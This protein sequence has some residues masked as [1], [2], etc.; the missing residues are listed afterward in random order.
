METIAEKLQYTSDAVDDIQ[1]AINEKGVEVDD[2][3]ELGL[4]GDKIREIKVFDGDIS[5]VVMLKDLV[6]VTDQYNY[7]KDCYDTEK[8]IAFSENDIIAKDI[9]DVSSLYT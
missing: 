9:E 3:I 5:A 1:A 6:D 7:N 4:Y 2:D 8:F